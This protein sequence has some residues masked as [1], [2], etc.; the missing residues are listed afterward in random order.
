MRKIKTETC[1]KSRQAKNNEER[2]GSSA[3]AIEF[4]LT[5]NTCVRVKC[6]LTDWPQCGISY[7]DTAL[8]FSLLQQNAHYMLERVGL[9]KLQEKLLFISGELRFKTKHRHFERAA[10]G[11]V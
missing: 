1:F 6:L 4:K 5:G 11:L 3:S 9:S 7:D 10:G 8:T 2:P